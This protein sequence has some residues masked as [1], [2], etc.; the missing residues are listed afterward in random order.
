MKTF[1]LTRLF[2]EKILLISLV[3]I[4]VLVWFSSLSTRVGK[5][6]TEWRITSTE[7]TTQK[8]WLSNRTAI[9]KQAAD[10]I[11]AFDPGST[12]DSTRLVGELN[13]FAQQAGLTNTS[14]EPRNPEQTNQFSVNTVQF[15]ARKA[16]MA[17]L[18]NFYKLVVKRS[19]YISLEQCTLMSASP[20]GTQLAAIFTV[21]SVEIAR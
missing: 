8:M 1:F 18:L 10:A 14:I 3:A 9:E 12:L 15:T 17:S 5:F 11:K 13:T 19:P 6:V 21:S 4:A 2:R 7:L 16:D 20:D